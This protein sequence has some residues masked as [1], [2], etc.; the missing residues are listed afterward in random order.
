VK[1]GTQLEYRSRPS[2]VVYMIGAVRPS[3]GFRK[4]GGVPPITARW[5]QHRPDERELGSFRQLSGL[6][7]SEYLSMLY[8][9]TISFPLQMAILTHS[10]FPVPIWRVLQVRNQL[11][12]LAPV[13]IGRPLDL[14]VSVAGHRILE[15]G[16]EIDLHAVASAGGMPA[17]EAINTFYVRGRFGEPERASPMTAAAALAPAPSEQLVAQWRMPADG[18]WRFGGLSGDFN[19]IHL[20]GWYARRFG[21]PRAFLHPQRVLGQ[22]LARLP[23]LDPATPQRLDTWLKG[24]VYYGAPVSLRSTGNGGDTVFALNVDGDKRPAIIG[25]LRAVGPGTRLNAGATITS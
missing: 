25:H 20:S 1:R 14:A 7:E 8:P 21:F 2:A 11:L 6:P 18:G 13:P 9:H 12:Q 23:A 24:P 5:L 16:A 22:C 10:T 4:A 19:G 3:P 15:K 17:W